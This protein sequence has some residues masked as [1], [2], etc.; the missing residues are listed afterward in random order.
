MTIKTEIRHSIH[1]SALATFFKTNTA[2]QKRNVY[3]CALRKAKA[4]QCEVSERARVL[5]AAS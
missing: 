4:E 2:E 5:R 3:V 1:K